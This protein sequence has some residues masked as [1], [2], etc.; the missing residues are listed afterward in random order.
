MTDIENAIFK[1]RSKLTPQESMKAIYKYSKQQEF[2]IDRGAD[3]RQ[4]MFVRR[5]QRALGSIQL[6]IFTL[7]ASYLTYGLI[8]GV[9]IALSPGNQ[10][11]NLLQLQSNQ[12]R[13]I[14]RPE[15]YLRDRDAEEKLKQ[16]SPLN[17]WH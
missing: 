3:W 1:D 11:D 13:Q 17:L 9:W 4:Y 6:T 14:Y 16:N 2:N 7:G 10:I 8:S 12:A 15:I 5:Q